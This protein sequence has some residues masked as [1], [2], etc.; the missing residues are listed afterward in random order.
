MATI[1]APFNFVPLS[2]KVF[3]PDWADQIS[4]DIPFSDGVSGTIELKI[5]A[6]SPLFVRNGHTRE[7][8]DANNEKYKSFSRTPD[9]QYFIPATSIKGA[10]RNVLEIMSFGKMNLDR[11]AMFAQREWDNEALYP[12]KKEQQKFRCGYIRRKGNAYEIIDCDKPYRIGH[13]RIDSYLKKELFKKYFSQSEGVD[14]TNEITLKGEVYDPKTAAFK[15]AL[16]RDFNLENLRFSLD[17]E[18]N[19]EYKENRLVVDNG[20][21]IEGDIVFTGQPDKWMYPRPTELTKNAGKF[22]DFVFLKPKTNAKKYDISEDIFN[23]FKFIYSDSTEWERA[24][25]LLD[26][27]GIP[28]FFR[29][30]QGIIKDFGL[31]FLYKLPYDKSPYETL[32]AGHKDLKPDLAECLFGY[33]QK[34]HSL[35]GRVQFSNAVSSDAE[36][37]T[38]VRL[39]L[40]SPKASY[41]PIY[42]AQNGNKGITNQYTTYNDG[43]ISGWKRYPV[44]ANTWSKSTGS[45]NIDTTIYPLRQGTA[46]HGTIRFHNLRPVELGALLS[47]LTFHDD[48]DCFYQFGQAKPYGFGK[49]KLNISL[50]CKEN[51]SPTYYMALFENIMQTSGGIGN[52][53]CNQNITELFTMAHCEVSAGQLLTYMSMSNNRDDNEFLSAKQFNEYLQLYSQLSKQKYHPKSLYAE[54]EEKINKEKEEIK[55]SKDAEERK[56]RATFNLL[57]F[58]A[59]QLFSDKKYEEAKA[60][61]EEANTFGIEDLL[62]KITLCNGELQKIETITNSSIE[63]VVKCSSINAFA[64]GMKKWVAIHGPID[65]VDCKQMAEVLLSA[66]KEMK[67]DKQREWQSFEKWKPIIDIIGNDVAKK[68]FNALS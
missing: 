45:D 1:K 59:D 11:N 3:F 65:E 46:F 36:I 42:I 61:Y 16:T 22:Y 50:S 49:S 31:A 7:D 55:A 15:Y 51:N 34:E 58:E 48:S 40:S 4:Q 56:K 30:E 18:R 54:Y 25:T 21:D 12:L 9:G 13:D 5:T 33:T 44:R 52:W 14:L 32:G 10:V 39:S 68:I 37:D 8:A 28:V 6:E 64:G 60:K 24:E 27:K 47:A 2:D 67:K 53:C 26:K 41:Y 63:D 17:E 66:M 43:K 20:G 19:N 35:R 38:E 29:M 62:N 23:H 57:K